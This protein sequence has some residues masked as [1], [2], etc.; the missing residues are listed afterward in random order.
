MTKK[1]IK[2]SDVLGDNYYIYELTSSNYTPAL[3]DTI[4]I[5]CT[6]KDVYGAAAGSKS[7]TLYQND[8][9][10]GAKTTNSSGVATWSITCSSAGLQK[11]NIK[12]T[13]IEVFVDNKAVS[14]HQ[15]GNITSDGKITTSHN[16]IYSTFVGVQDSTGTLYKASKINSDIIIDGTAHANIG[17]NANDNQSAINTAINTALGNKAD[18]THSHSLSS[19]GG[20]VTVEKQSTAE[21]GYAHTYVIKQNNTQVGSKINIP[22]D[23][24]V[25]S[26]TLNTCSTANNPVSGYSVGDKYL[27]FVVNAKDNSATD[28][29]LYVLVSDLVDDVTIDSSWVANSTNPVQSK[30]IKTALDGKANSSHTHNATEIQDSSAHNRIGSGANDNQANINN[31]IDLALIDLDENILY[32][33]MDLVGFDKFQVKD[34]IN[35]NNWENSGCTYSNGVLTFSGSNS[36]TA[37]FPTDSLVGEL[38]DFELNFDYII[39]DGLI[40]GDIIDFDIFGRETNYGV[41]EADINDGYVIIDVSFKSEN[42][43]GTITSEASGDE[44]HIDDVGSLNPYTINAITP[45]G[46]STKIANI[47]YKAN[48]IISLNDNKEDVYNKVTSI[49]SSSTDTQYPSAKAVKS[50]LD[51]KL[52]KQE[53]SLITV[54]DVGILSSEYHTK[55]R[56][57]NKGA[58]GGSITSNAL[59]STF[60]GNAFYIYNFPPSV[61]SVTMN[62]LSIIPGNIHITNG[63]GVEMASINNLSTYTWTATSDEGLG[64]RIDDPNKQVAYAVTSITFNMDNWIDKIYPIGATYISTVEIEPSTLFGGVWERIKDRFLLSSGDTYT[65]ASTGGEATHTL[66]INEMPQH[67][68]SPPTWVH[69]ASTN[70]NTGEYN[71]T[72]A[73][74]SNGNTYVGSA[75]Q[76]NKDVGYTGGGQAHNNMPPYLVVCMWKRIA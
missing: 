64:I 3:N 55:D 45:V 21:S 13:S 37:T 62:F 49:S 54:T 59:A 31:S 73:T 5:T 7:I 58:S 16:G 66:T 41:T 40:L 39:D 29:H 51:L 9:S 1:T 28:E 12:D 32:T 57:T 2:A 34:F 38:G 56:W 19:L 42:N 50:S 22:K 8:T 71:V 4:T 36:F 26:A 60:Q 6:M 76:V 48:N 72:R 20:T 15:H 11:F 14:S 24:L 70:G 23:F 74:G 75:P 47:R 44:W 65:N 52:S 46:N 30:V 27:D 67:T 61:T 25:K 43:I 63:E 17:S 69:Y 53:D 68:H 10:K 18:S 35:P 33:K